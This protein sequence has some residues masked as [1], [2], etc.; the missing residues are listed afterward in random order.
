MTWHDEV[1]LSAHAYWQFLGKHGTY[2]IIILYII[3]SI[4][5]NI[6]VI[7]S[8]VS[9]YKDAI[10]SNRKASIVDFWWWDVHF[11]GFLNTFLNVLP[12][13]CR[14]CLHR[15]E[16]QTFIFLNFCF[17]SWIIVQQIKIIWRWIWA[18]N[19]AKIYTKTNNFNRA[20]VILCCNVH[21]ID[22]NP[23]PAIFNCTSEEGVR[24][25]EGELR[26][27]SVKIPLNSSS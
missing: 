13:D 22:Y 23:L 5:Y 9:L 10:K 25:K 4:Y 2:N 21:T 11:H 14:M 19:H 16:L 20:W 17:N 8:L 15:N 27:V 26:N 24:R 6:Y 1:K 3:I 12:A 7:C 18:G